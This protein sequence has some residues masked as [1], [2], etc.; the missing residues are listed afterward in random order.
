MKKATYNR[1][2]N[3]VVNTGYKKFDKATICIMDGNVIAPT[4]YSTFVRP[5]KETECNGFIN[6]EGHLTKYDIQHFRNV[7]K[8]IMGI[9]LDKENTESH[10][11]YE[12]FV[13]KDI[14]GHVLTTAD[15]KKFVASDVMYSPRYDIRI[16]Y[17]NVIK[18]MIEYITYPGTFKLPDNIC[19]LL[20]KNSTEYRSTVTVGDYTYSCM[21]HH[22]GHTGESVEVQNKIVEISHK[23]SNKTIDAIAI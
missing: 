4:Q 11:L 8:E 5:W 21:H 23:G 7:S 16:K 22:M 6:E 3:Q 1:K 12:F 18:D 19:E 15:T 2:G 13:E 10:I 14:I 9:L 17:E 20:A